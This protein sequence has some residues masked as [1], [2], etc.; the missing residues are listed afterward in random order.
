MIKK[1]IVTAAFAAA[2]IA[3]AT[4]QKLMIGEKAPEL[5]VKEWINQRPTQNTARLIEF[6]HSSDQ[7]SQARLAALDAYAKKFGGLLS[8]VLISREDKASIQSSALSQ[9]RAY[10]VGADDEGKT[11]A[12]YSVQYVPFSVL[13]DPKGKVVWFGNPANLEESTI[14]GALK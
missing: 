12:A 2:S 14:S 13:V 5:K 9:P 10:A 7:K 6:Y 3:G 1:L 8:I 4:A 11:F